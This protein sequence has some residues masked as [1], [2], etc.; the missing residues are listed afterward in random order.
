MRY[1][2]LHKLINSSQSTRNYFL[3]LP[4]ETQMR[5]HNN[6]ELVHSAFELRSLVETI[7]S[8]DRSVR[9][10]DSLDRYFR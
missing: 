9:L 7:E 1:P 5:L 2:N 3:S 10:S 8:Y 6:G 4:V